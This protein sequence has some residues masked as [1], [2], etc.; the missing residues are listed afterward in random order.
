MVEVCGHLP[1]VVETL[2]VQTANPLWQEW[3][4]GN[5]RLQA[6]ASECSQGLPRLY[7]TALYIKSD[8]L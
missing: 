2:A 3:L 1:P 5:L 4:T 8:G 6:S 7:S